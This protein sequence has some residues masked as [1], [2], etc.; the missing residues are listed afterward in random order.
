MIFVQCVLYLL[1][2]Y[3]RIYLSEACQY[4][5]VEFINLNLKYWRTDRKSHAGINSYL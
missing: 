1:F 2:P 5:I 4:Q 3:R